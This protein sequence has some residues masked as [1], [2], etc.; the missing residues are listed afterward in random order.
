MEWF[1]LVVFIVV[2]AGGAFW[3]RRSS[4]A[5]HARDI[6]DARAEA[7]RWY[8]RLGGQV[9]NLHGDDPA[10]RQ[11]LV[12][13]GERYTAAGSQLEQARSVRQFALA[14]ETA[15]EGLMYARAA[16]LALGL[17]PGPD[18]PP[19]AAAQGAGQL[20]VAREVDVQGQH[21]KA[22]PQPG[23]DTPYYYPGGRVHGRPVPAGWYSQQWWK[24]ALAGAAGAIGGLLIFDA[25]FSPAFAD[26][27]YGYDAG[28]AEG[29][30]EGAAAGGDGGDYGGDYG[31]ITAAATGAATPASV[32]ATSAAATSSERAG[33]GGRPPGRGRASRMVFARPRGQ[34]RLA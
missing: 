15:I 34:S 18:L 12:D 7:Q 25:L 16:R 22:G 6:A 3:L 21:Y 20:T 17:D 28:F 27:G 5:R 23:N 33:K 19:L 10:V 29:Y 11:A 31:A 14:R 4:A 1:F 26:P 8:E 9:M 2:I 32:A 30:D 13:A 24:P